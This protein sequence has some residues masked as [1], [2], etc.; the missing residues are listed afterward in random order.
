MKTA[1]KV[2]LLLIV[3]LNAQAQVLSRD[4]WSNLAY[5]DMSDW[6]RRL[7]G[8]YPLDYG[9]AGAPV[10]FKPWGMEPWL[11]GVERDGIPWQRISD[12]LYESNLDSPEELD[13]L[14]LAFD[15]SH[16]FSTLKLATR[17]LPSDTPRTEL[18][19]R[20]G[21]YGF[22]RI[23][24]AHAQNFSSK[25]RAE[26]RGR[27][28][29]YNGLRELISKSKFYSLHGRLTYALGTS[30]K[31]TFEYGGSNVEA[32]SPQILR[33][34]SNRIVRPTIYSERE[35]G[36]LKLRRGNLKG[37]WEFGA[38]LRQDREDRDSY[39]GL[40]EQFA[41]GYAELQRSWKLTAVRGRVSYE[42][43]RYTFPGVRDARE[44]AVTG[45]LNV[46]Q[47]VLIGTVSG[48]GQYRYRTSFD[49][50][51][52]SDK[53]LDDNSA[54]GVIE[55]RPVGGISVV[56]DAVEAQATMPKF[57]SDA[58]Y[59]IGHRPL[60]IDNT[61]YAH[62]Y[63]GGWNSLLLPPEGPSIE[64]RSWHFA[65]KGNINSSSF[66]AGW[67]HV[68]SGL[69]YAVGG[70]T[71]FVTR[72]FGVEVWEGPS[73]SCNLKVL[74]VLRFQSMSDV[75]LDRYDHSRALD[76]RSLSRLVFAR[77]FF[78]SQLHIDSYVAYEH[79]GKRRVTSDIKSQVIGP[80]H[81]MHLQIAATI[82]G[83]TLVWGAENL[84]AQH[85]E[86]LPG[87]LMIRKEEYFGFRWTLKL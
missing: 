61:F 54:Y 34:D 8:M 31:S 67:R 69:G 2:A 45:V 57:W 81:L 36:T 32:Q 30:W 29:W 72:G 86:Y 73:V 55:S 13:S 25:L 71:L 23:D 35:Y 64:H 40:W 56:F 74:P 77:D 20:E 66:D 60:F 79:L 41:Y 1:L 70:D 10:L 19:V 6:I 58:H 84:T 47:D 28:F 53:I 42:D 59:E 37:A 24:F 7:P 39:F 22:G 43:A 82:E 50:G 21:Y 27:L 75:S 38:H 48:R 52:Y 17:A 33:P 80:A 18:A 62:Q 46:S 65:L 76:T 3:S 68:Q 63:F 78:K 5:E 44:S 14:T 49:Q 85:Y 51:L 4:A 15:G 87:Y 16:P 9:V 12:G 11:V 83:V 26:G